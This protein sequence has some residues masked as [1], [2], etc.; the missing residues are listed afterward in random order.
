MMHLAAIV[1]LALGASPTEQFEAF[2]K[3]FAEKRDAITTIEASFVQR[4]LT[5]DDVYNSEGTVAYR[6]PRQLLFRYADPEPQ[7]LLFD[8]DVLYEYDIEVRQLVAR[9]LDNMQEAETLFLA[10]ENNPDRLRELYDVS[11]SLPVALEG[12][13]CNGPAIILKPK[14]DATDP[15]FQEAR[16]DLREEDYLPCRIHVVTDEDTQFFIDF[17][18]YKV[19]QPLGPDALSYSL[20]EGVTIVVDEELVEIK[21]TKG[22]R[23]PGDVPRPEGNEG[24]ETP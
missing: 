3:T 16:L 4:S 8:Q 10:F 23:V 21:D 14:A 12:T 15:L 13:E 11:I 6:Q 1:A 5:P 9:K 20:D 24:A 18:D 17:S 2:F 7:N 22:L 19:N